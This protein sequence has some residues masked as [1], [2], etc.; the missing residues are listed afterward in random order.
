MTAVARILRTGVDVLYFDV[1]VVIRADPFLHI[2]ASLQMQFASNWSVHTSALP[3]P[4]PAPFPKQP[5][6][7]DK[8]RSVRPAT[9]LFFA[10]SEVGPSSV[11]ER[12]AKIARQTEYSDDDDGEG[13]GEDDG[14]SVESRILGVCGWV[15]Q[16]LKQ[17]RGHQTSATLIPPAWHRPWRRRFASPLATPF[18]NDTTLAWICVILQTSIA[19]GLLAALS[20]DQIL[21]P[22]LKPVRGNWPLWPPEAS[23]GL[24]A[25]SCGL[26]WLPERPTLTTGHVYSSKVTNV[27][28]RSTF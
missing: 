11:L 7:P 20:E 26:P 16:L 24:Q 17:S 1:D 18:A 3:P 27:I 8:Q 15:G 4:P 5:R 2:D 14:D 22:G 6:C 23:R 12:M 9:W 10:K 25:S 28:L 21:C 13:N 19:L